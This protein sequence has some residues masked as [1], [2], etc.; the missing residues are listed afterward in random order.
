M[1][2]KLISLKKHSKVMNRRQ[3]NVAGLIIT[4]GTSLLNTAEIKEVTKI[5]TQRKTEQLTNK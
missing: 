5:I 2:I 4:Q 3:S 1:E